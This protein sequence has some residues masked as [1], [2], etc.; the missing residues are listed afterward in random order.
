M[1]GYS[2]CPFDLNLARSDPTAVIVWRRLNSFHGWRDFFGGR[3]KKFNAEHAEFAEIFL[4]FW[5]IS[6]IK[7]FCPLRLDLQLKLPAWVAAEECPD[8]RFRAFDPGVA[9]A[10][11]AFENHGRA[12]YASCGNLTVDA[13]SGCS[14]RTKRLG[15]A[16][17]GAGIRR[18]PEV[19]VVIA[20]R[21][22]VVKFSPEP[23]ASG[24]AG[25][26]PARCSECRSCP[27]LGRW[28]QQCR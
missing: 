24:R 10:D 27:K 12:V 11:F 28:R 15:C 13:G 18:G 16:S 22:V 21:L 1:S 4:K 23:D 5:A 26:S 25:Q 14:I 19:D 6:A 17:G 7:A 8:F 20:R 3:Q 2:G 9:Y